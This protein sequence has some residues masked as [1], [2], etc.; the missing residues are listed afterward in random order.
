MIRSIDWLICVVKITARDV[1][2]LC[3]NLLK[4]LDFSTNRTVT[5]GFQLTVLSRRVALTAQMLLCSD[6]VILTLV[7]FCCTLYINIHKTYIQ[8][9]SLSK[10]SLIISKQSL[11]YVVRYDLYLND[12]LRNM[13]LQFIEPLQFLYKD[14]FL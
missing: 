2:V 4:N 8:S 1:V 14:F 10:Y 11:V 6:F 3:H 7:I 9:S 12:Q 5:A 13:N